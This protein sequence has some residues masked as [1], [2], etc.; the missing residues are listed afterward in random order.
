MRTFLSIL[1]VLSSQVANAAPRVDRAQVP[2]GILYDLVVPIA[3]V[4][5][6]D[7]S[8]SAPSANAGTLRQAVFELSR[9]S[10]D[11]RAWPDPDAF[12]DDGGHVIRIGLLDV[13]YDRIRD[14]NRARVEGDQ[15]ILE[16]GAVT[17]ARALIAAPTRAYSYQG[18]E[19]SFELDSRLFVGTGSQ[20]PASAEIDFG[21]GE[22]FRAI[23]FDETVV[24]RYPSTGS[25]VGRV[26][27]TDPRGETGQMAFDFEVRALAAPA[28]ND[29]IPLTATQPYNGVTATGRAFVYLSSLNAT[30]TRPAVVVEGFD[31]DN[32]MNWD[33]LYALLNQEGLV[34][35]LR[36]RG[37]DAVVLDFTESTEYI[38]ANSFVLVDLLHQ[39][40]AVVDPS[41]TYPVVGASMGG[42]VARYALAWMEQ[43]ADPHR[44]RNF[45]SFDVPHAGANIPLG[46]QYWLDF[47]SDR[48]ADAA[49]LLGRLD[50]PAARQMLLYHHTSPPTNTGSADP[51]RLAFESDL[52]GLGD[53]P[54]QPRLVALSNG[55]GTM[56]T[57][58]FNAGAQIISYN[59]SD[60]FVTVRGNVWAVPNGP[61]TQI[62]Q[63][64]V[65]P[66]FLPADAM[67]VSVTGTLPWDGAPG[68]SRNSM[69]QMD[70]VVAP[71]G[72][73]VALHQSHCFIPT[74]SALDIAT[75]NPFYDVAG[76]PQLLSHTPFDNL[77][78]PT[79]NEPHVTVT[80][81]NAPWLLDEIDPPATA[82]RDVSR[83]PAFSLAAVAP[84]PFDMETS[85]RWDLS[86]AARVRV[87]VFDVAGRR[88]TTLL[89]GQRP[90][91]RGE[92][93]WAGR[94]D[95]GRAVAAG[96]YFVRLNAMGEARTARA[97]IVR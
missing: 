28:P 45:I 7:G 85:V 70:A 2:S 18:G 13:T 90:A 84:N 4:E 39:L 32:T 69:A 74:I 12:R 76:D 58:G 16:P 87:D 29:T 33:E 5:Q 60:F 61:S 38:Q 27:V 44:V 47:F 79:I 67:N 63:A 57:Q 78:V 46:I 96:V 94:D 93:R 82:V 66:I 11:P 50:R 23:R 9:A 41:A 40:Q 92:V 20:R 65:D 89:D 8:P 1:L 55:S 86:R 14:S 88:V 3:H 49:H 17:A 30:L 25:Y 48:S 42:L 24:I 10:L 71:Y 34:E 31:I 43:N 6:F 35:E 53:Y 36:T 59:Y 80:P 72:D 91:G 73:I 81:G 62:L 56:A 21:N 37:Y 26:R 22:G 64:L 52:A 75:A 68:G 15:L 97:V 83:P 54:A 19:V 77:Y 95:R 51:L